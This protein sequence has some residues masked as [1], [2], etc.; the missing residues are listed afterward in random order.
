MMSSTKDTNDTFKGRNPDIGIV[1]HEFLNIMIRSACSK[2]K[3]EPKIDITR[4]EA[5]TKLLAEYSEI[6]Q[7]SNPVTWRINRYYNEKV[8]LYL[9]KMDN[10]LF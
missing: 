9:K 10:V 8:D 5:V 7:E 6:F 3:S 2:Y 4:A 1:R